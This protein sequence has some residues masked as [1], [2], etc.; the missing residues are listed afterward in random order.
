M[1]KAIILH[2]VVPMRADASEAAEQLTQLL[3]GELCDVLDQVP[4]WT[5]IRSTQD[6]QE[7]WV[8]FKMITILSEEESNDLKRANYAVVQ[9]PH[10]YARCVT[11]GARIPLSTGT[12]LP[13]YENGL[14]RL[15][16]ITYTLPLGAVTRQ[17]K[18]ATGGDIVRLAMSHL[19]EPYLWGGKNS[20]GMDCSGLT[21][22]VMACFGHQL[23]RNARE[24]VTQGHV[25]DDWMMV[26]Q[27]DLLFFDHAD[28]DPHS[29]SIS[30]V[31][32]YMGH[33]RIIHA[34]GE[35]HIDLVDAQGIYTE[36]GHRT[37]HLVAIRRFC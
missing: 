18:R 32:I 27:G 17:G 34:S 15:Q 1:S 3:W 7:G 9:R 21:Q 30:H 35:V 24:Q 8:D 26:K 16:G 10:V 11:S 13:H 4:R 31:G 25:I 37:H 23:L 33:G 29:T 2:S 36:N 6:G 14:F 12:H 20:M 28:R 19:H 5:R 22:V